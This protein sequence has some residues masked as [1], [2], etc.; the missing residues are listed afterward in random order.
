MGRSYKKHPW[1]KSKSYGSKRAA[2]K[3]VRV[4]K[5][6]PMRGSGWK[7]TYQAWD[8]HEQWD[9]HSREQAIARAKREGV[10]DIKEYLQRYW[11]PFFRRK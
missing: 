2:S 4:T 6:L 7:R 9:Y 11:Y 1:F 10:T 8:L 3:R 5:E